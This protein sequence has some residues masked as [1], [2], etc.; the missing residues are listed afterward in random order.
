M[1]GQLGF[2]E[3]PLQVV[4]RN[5]LYRIEVGPFKD[6]GRASRAAQ[7]IRQAV[8]LKPLVVNR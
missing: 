4:G 2:L 8:D 6:R 5:D 1:Q 7:R 3:A